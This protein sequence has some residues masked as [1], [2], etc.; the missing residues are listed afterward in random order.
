MNLVDKIRDQF[1]IYKLYKNKDELVILEENEKTDRYKDLAPRDEIE[2][3]DEYFKA[4]GWSLNQPNI[5]NI[6]IAGPYGSGKSSIIQSFIKKHNELNYVNISLANFLELNSK[7]S[8]GSNDDKNIDDELMKGILKQLFYS[9]DKHKIPQSRYRKLQVVNLKKIFVFLFMVFILI[10]ACLLYFINNIHD[11]LKQ[12]INIAKDNTG[13]SSLILIILGIVLIVMILMILTKI[14]GTIISKM[15][16]KEIGISKNINANLEEEKDE[17]IFDKNMDEIVYFFEATNINLIFFEDLDRYNNATIF[18]KLREL[19]T[20][21]NQYENIKKRIVFVYAIRDDMFVENDRTKF[22]DF[23]LPIIPVINS[24]NSEEK[25]LNR[26]REEEIKGLKIDLSKNYINLISPYINDMRILDN[27]YNEFI[28]YKETLQKASELNLKDYVMFSIMLFKN[29]YPNDFADIQAEKGIIKDVF[30]QKESKIKTIEQQAMEKK[31]FLIDSINQAENDTLNSIKETK[32]VMLSFM[33]GYE[34]CPN[35][36]WVNGNRYYSYQI[37][38][39]DFDLDKLRNNCN[40]NYHSFR[41]NNNYSVNFDGLMQFVE[42]NDFIERCRYIKNKLPENKKILQEK[43]EKI[44][45]EIIELRKL[46]IKELIDRYGV[47]DILSDNVRSNKLL[48]FLLRNGFINEDYANYINNFYTDSITIDDM[49][50]ILSIRN[51]EAFEFDYKLN[52]IEKIVDKLQKFEFDQKEIYNFDLLNYLISSKT[53]MDKRNTFIRQLCDENNKSWK[54]INE[55]FD[56]ANN[57]GEF[58]ALLSQNW[59][60]MWNYIYLNT[61]LT[62][63]RKDKYLENICNSVPIEDIITLNKDNN[64]KK[65][66]EEHVDILQRMNRVPISN[67]KCIIEKCNIYFS[68]IDIYGIQSNLIEWIFDNKHFVLNSSIIQTIFEFKDYKEIR[69]LNSCNYT[70][71]KSL[72]YAPLMEMVENNLENYIKDIVLEIESNIYEKLDYVLEMINNLKN[73]DLSMQLIKKEEIILDNLDKCKFDYLC[74]NK[75]NLK[76]IYDEWI[77]CRKLYGSWQNLITYWEDFGITD[78]LLYYLEHSLNQIVIKRYPEDIDFSLIKDIIYS[79][80]ST[81]S[82]ELFIDHVPLLNEI[83]ISKINTNHMKILLDKKYFNFD[84]NFASEVK[85]NHLTLYN[86]SLVIY[87]E[88]V[89]DSINDY[90][91]TI[92]NIDYI[93]DS[94]EISENDKV[95][96]ISQSNINN[97]SR[98]IALFLRNIKMELELSVFEKT[99]DQLENEEKYQ[100]LLNQIVI[101]DNKKISYYLSQLE[102]GYVELSDRSTRHNVKL[103]DNDY[104]KKLVNYLKRTSYLTSYKIEN[105]YIICRVKKNN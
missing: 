71:I 86:Y 65:Y 58:I 31:H 7:K 37:M 24:T 91:L 42:K 61:V 6:A 90:Q 11:K 85:E 81:N 100:L 5:Y 88:E 51:H 14:I 83:D 32:I 70:A 35:F 39:D 29:L 45:R 57:Q 53:N 104:N 101:L 73:I 4:L 102:N 96:I 79:D 20:I 44:D 19:N 13:F 63:E 3:A 33:T 38:A 17:S 36:I 22:F 89:I 25:L 41:N 8:P 66:F 49:N 76:L 59:S 50:F 94:T 2:K 34:G 84:P 15:S 46:S 26:I 48:V 40:I 30:I 87:K 92:E 67:M 60:N 82:F 80:L 77:N 93:I 103:D 27:T 9:V 75:N 10:F 28:T 78:S 98:K 16:I 55:Y 43:I 95:C 69:K 12:A 21:L 97:F 56:I 1:E 105:G 72:N 54:F 68:E 52:K 64:I 74:E 47:E 23:I 62:D 18:I 99:W